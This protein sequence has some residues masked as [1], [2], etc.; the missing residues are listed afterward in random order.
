M[1]LPNEA[2]SI[3]RTYHITAPRAGI[4]TAA[5]ATAITAAY[6][7]HARFVRRVGATQVEYEARDHERANSARQRIA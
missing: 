1:T 5:R 6:L 7:W 2:P 3:V 4:I